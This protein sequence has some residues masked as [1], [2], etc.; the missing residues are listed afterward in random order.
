MPSELM[1]IGMPLSSSIL[2]GGPFCCAVP[3]M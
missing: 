2:N 1:P 3:L